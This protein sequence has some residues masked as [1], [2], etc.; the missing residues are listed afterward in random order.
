MSKPRKPEQVIV[1]YFTTAPLE[2]AE[3]V[4]TVVRGIVDS[5]RPKATKKTTSKPRP[6]AAAVSAQTA[7]N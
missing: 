7:A 4:L 5:R 1:E 6:V 3:S 2:A